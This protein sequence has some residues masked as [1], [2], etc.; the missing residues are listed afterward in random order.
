MNPILCEKQ[1]KLIVM[2]IPLMFPAPLA[3][4]GTLPLSSESVGFRP[5]QVHVRQ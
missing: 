5:K 4:G 1:G 3:S 2:S